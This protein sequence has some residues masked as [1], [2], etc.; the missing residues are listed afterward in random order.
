MIGGLRRRDETRDGG[1]F[2]F[3]SSEST[4]SFHVHTSDT[5]TVAAL[6]LFLL[7][8]IH[9]LLTITTDTM[10]INERSVPICFPFFR[11]RIKA[12]SY[13]G[14][15]ETSYIDPCLKDSS[16]YEPNDD[17]GHETS[18]EVNERSAQEATR[19]ERQERK[20]GNEPITFALAALPH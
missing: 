2:A 15:F 11:E 18:K 16:I 4:V 13:H 17:W 20:G 8:Q 3:E 1:R 6:F 7:S 14:S 5:I 10:L 19:R 9:L 12:R